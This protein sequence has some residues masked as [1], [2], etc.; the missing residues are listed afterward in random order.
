MRRNNC[1]VTVAVASNVC[2]TIVCTG[3][4]SDDE[5]R[6]V[7]EATVDKCGSNE[8]AVIRKADNA[9][10]RALKLKRN[11]E[12]TERRTAQL[13]K[14]HEELPDVCFDVLIAHIEEYAEQRSTYLSIPCRLLNPIP[15]S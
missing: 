6:K 3:K 5:I 2:L 7:Q 14:V 11:S 4:I 15:L 12:R 8:A 9:V 13:M 10:K 1:Y